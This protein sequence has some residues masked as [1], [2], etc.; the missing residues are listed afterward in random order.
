MINVV[1]RDGVVE[2]WGAIVDERQ[3]E[4]LKVA[5]QNI[6]GVKEVKDYLAWVEPVSGVIIDPRDEVATR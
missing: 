4:A 3:R 2:L 1:V 5:A 6:Q